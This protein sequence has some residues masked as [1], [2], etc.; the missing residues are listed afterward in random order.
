MKT[1]KTMKLDKLYISRWDGPR[2]CGYCVRVP[3][4]PSKL[5]SFSKYRSEAACLRAARE[6][7]DRLCKKL[8]LPKT[9]RVVPVTKPHKRN[10]LQ[11]LGVSLVRKAQYRKGTGKRIGW[12]N[13]VQAQIK[14]GDLQLKKEFEIGAGR[15]KATAIKLATQARREMEASL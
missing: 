6:L 14:R 5:F 4:T 8:R 13:I 9:P 10:K 15:S 3:S 2:W 1:T 11:I 12:R 7:R